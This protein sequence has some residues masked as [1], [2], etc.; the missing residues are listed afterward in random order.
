MGLFKDFAI[1][2]KDFGANGCRCSD[3][4]YTFLELSDFDPT[5]RKS[6]LF[7]GDFECERLKFGLPDVLRAGFGA[8]VGDLGLK[9]GD[10]KELL[11]NL[12]SEKPLKG[13]VAKLPSSKL[14]IFFLRDFGLSSFSLLGAWS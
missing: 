4:G 5:L 9:F 2:T 10:R 12:G 13:F 7:L 14:K 3:F 11:G 6:K 8:K 1:K